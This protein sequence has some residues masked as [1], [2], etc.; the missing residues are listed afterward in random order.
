[1]ECP[2][3][4]SQV[5]PR[6]VA[7]PPRISQ[8][9]LFVPRVSWFSPENRHPLSAFPTLCP[10][11]G[12]CGQLATW[13][14]WPPVGMARGVLKPTA[15]RLFLCGAPEVPPYQKRPIFGQTPH[16]WLRAVVQQMFVQCEK[17][18]Y[19]GTEESSVSVVLHQSQCRG[20]TCIMKSLGSFAK[21]EFR[22]FGTAPHDSGE[23]QHTFQ[24]VY[25][26]P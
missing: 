20:G 11:R 26:H 17:P 4:D 7:L 18:R 6:N 16:K 9:L 12:R 21:D 24:K 19:F 15:K 2:K 8:G 23:N 13:L 25:K 10:Q 3:L 5:A 14:L 1:M 22:I